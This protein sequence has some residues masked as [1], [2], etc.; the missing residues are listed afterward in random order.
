[1]IRSSKCGL[2]P[3]WP[4]KKSVAKGGR[5]KDGA[6][7]NENINLKKKKDGG[8]GGDSRGS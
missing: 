7:R 5:R 3:L 2:K 4:G 6:K 1:M 8:V